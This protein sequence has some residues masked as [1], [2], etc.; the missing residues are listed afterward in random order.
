MTPRAS[1]EKTTI[2]AA[3]MA[4]LVL[5][6]GAAA[7]GADPG[8]GASQD[9][10]HG[11]W[12]RS[13]CDVESKN[14]AAC[15][16]KVVSDSSGD[17]LAGATPP[18]GAV[19]PA[20]FHSGYN[21][22]LT[23]SGTPIVAIVDAYDDPSAE[24]DLGKFDTQYGL[25]ACTTANGCFT[26]VNENGGTSYPASNAG[27]DLEISL[28]VQTVHSICQNCR[29]LLVEASS[30]NDSD[31]GTA[32]NTAARLGAVAISNSWGGNEFSGEQTEDDAYFNHPGVAI[33]VS[34]G[35][36]GYGTGWPAASPDVT[37]VGG[38]TLNLDSSGSYVGESAWADGGSGCSSQEAKPAW[39]TDG[40]CSKRTDADV[41]ADADPNT[42]AAV[43][44][45]VTYQHQ[46]GWFQVGGTSLSSPLIASVYAL[47]GAGGANV[48]E[49][50]IPYADPN[51]NTDLHDVTSGSNGS[52][53]GSILCNA[54][55]GFDGPT[56]LGTPNGTGAFS[57]APP[58]PPAP[59]FSLAVSSQS[60]AVVASTGGSPTYAVSSAIVSGASN[61]VTLSAT[62]LPSGV[63][64]TFV[65]AS[66]QAGSASTLTLTVPAGVAAKTYTFEVTGAYPGSTPT[67][68]INAS[69]VV[70]AA[71]KPDFA[72]AVSP[73]AG[74]VS[75]SG[76]T[77]FTVTITPVNGFGGSV[78]LSVSGLPSRVTGAFSPSST[79]STST[80]TLTARNARR[81]GARVATITGRSGSVSHSTTV[82]LSVD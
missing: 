49:A 45:S 56:G 72:I 17:P 51:R 52:C 69:L 5:V 42:G 74:S 3:L 81:S 1:F 62:G 68:T 54:G 60:T 14:G 13:V 7:S 16:A 28:D 35:D 71:P 18:A 82:A 26:K 12:F 80:L 47:A 61:T 41:A 15:Q 48:N 73:G 19:T 22:P 25:P 31:L 63:T 67:H 9:H 77:T 2:A 57:P 70:Q 58:G 8:Q 32:E 33:T 4:V 37:A 46:S 44:D 23:A 11:A 53:G 29:I 34:S 27:W 6:V 59:D 20:R 79:T 43:Y 30:A 76:S 36:S 10:S 39:Q 38:T 75:G 66:L 24:A 50:S 55:P 21:L 65:P 40:A 78:S 64:A